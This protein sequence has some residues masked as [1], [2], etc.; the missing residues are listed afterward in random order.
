MTPTSTR[1]VRV[2]TPPEVNGGNG[3]E[4]FT[5]TANGAGVRFDRIPPAPFSIDIGTTE[6]LT[7][8]ANGGED[9]FPASGNLAALIRITVDGG[10]GH[11]TISGSNGNDV[12]LGGP[13]NDFVDGQQGNDVALLGS[14]D[15][16]VPVGSRRRQRRC[17]GSGCADTM[18]FNG[19]NANENFDVSANGQRVRFFRN[20]GNVV[21]G[22]RRRRADQPQ[23]PRRRRQPGRPRHGRHGS[24]RD[25][26][27]PGRDSR[28]RRWRWRSP[29]A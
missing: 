17:R 22:H 21:D 9:S 4:Q 13:G 3:A 16:V 28:H 6:N 24:H 5:A 10:A 15:D 12:L 2:S 14:E 7:L 18:V 27:G 29:T 20:V 19:N 1:A 26:H 23:R 25:R 11:D 8:N